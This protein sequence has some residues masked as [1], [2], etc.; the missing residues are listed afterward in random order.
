MKDEGGRM[1]R[2]LR[3]FLHP[4]SLIL[5]PLPIL[6]ALL[7]G[8][9]TSAVAQT[10]PSRPVRLI[11]PQTPGSSTDII[12][13][14]VAQR[15]GERL[16]QTFVVDNRAGAGSL[17]GIELVARA[18]PD[19]YTLL[20]V[21]SSITIHPVLHEKL[22]FD[23]IRDFAPIT[24]VATY[25]SILVLNPNVPA[26]SVTEL[27]QL[28][29][30]KPGQLNVGSSGVGTGTHLSAELFRSMTGVK[31]TYI[32]FRGGAPAITALLGGEV[33][34]SFAT[35]PL[36]L[37][38]ARSGRLRALGVTSSR[39]SPAAPDLPTIAESGVPGYDHGAWN[40][41]LAPAG[42]PRAIVQKLNQ[43]VRAVLAL[44]DVRERLLAEGAEPL[45]STPEEFGSIMRAEMVKWAKV[46]K[47]T[48][49]KA[50]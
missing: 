30:A 36:V 37:P 22:S 48:G 24:Q 31:W 19:G 12:A 7:A 44:A 18:V 4:T 25:P 32:Q 26:R 45:S 47:Q 5:H 41:M 23:T 50:E 13:R 14:L 21:A 43:E 10:Y 6:A 35:M 38:H 42:T 8:A 17:I 39:R 28:A 15:L 29:R 9:A 3:V 27:I 40:A 46:I 33:Q 49:M 34:L 20:V 2:G 16:G 1:T 11:V